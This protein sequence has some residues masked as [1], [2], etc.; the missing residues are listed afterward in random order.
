MKETGLRA[1][2]EKTKIL[3]LL[4]NEADVSETARGPYETV[5]GFNKT[6]LNANNV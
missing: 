3:E 2:A 4:N 6:T 1:I 5:D